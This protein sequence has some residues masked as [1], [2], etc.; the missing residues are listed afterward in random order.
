MEAVELDDQGEICVDGPALFLGYLRDGELQTF[1][2]EDG[3]F[4]TGDLG[5]W[6]ADGEFDDRR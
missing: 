5:S 1:R 2:D 3:L 4:H 6:S